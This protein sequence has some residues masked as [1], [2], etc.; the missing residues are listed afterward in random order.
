MR[1][2]SDAGRDLG[3]EEADGVAGEAGHGGFGA[4]AVVDVDDY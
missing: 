3:F 4:E 2:P 1:L